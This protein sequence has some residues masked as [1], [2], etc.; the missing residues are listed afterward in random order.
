M[1]SVGR[2]YGCFLPLGFVWTG[3]GIARPFRLLR[4]L[5]R[6]GIRKENA[7]PEFQPDEQQ[8]TSIDGARVRNKSQSRTR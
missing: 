4:L 8:R 1:V 2:E 5:R 6:K 3:A 7:T